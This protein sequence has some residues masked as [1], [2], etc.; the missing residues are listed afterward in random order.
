GVGL[1][2]LAEPGA[3]AATTARQEDA[4]SR[5][6][7][8][9][10][11]TRHGVKKTVAAAAVAAEGRFPM[12]TVAEVIGVS[13]SNLIERMRE[14]AKK[15]IGRPPL[16]DDRRRLRRSSPS[17][18]PTATGVSTPSSSAKRWPLA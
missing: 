3:R 11:R 13:R 12:K 7:Q 9:G 6:P 16:P 15:R 2:S 14:R 1:P 8:G 18:R 4:G 10:V 17:C 5:D